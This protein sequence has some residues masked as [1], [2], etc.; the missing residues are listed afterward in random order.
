MKGTKSS[1]KD[2]ISPICYLLPF[3]LAC[4]QNI[5]VQWLFLLFVLSNSVTYSYY[6]WSSLDMGV[7]STSS[8]CL[9]YAD[10]D[11]TLTPKLGMHF[12][13]LPKAYEF[14]NV[15]AK[16]AWFSVRKDLRRS[17][18]GEIVWKPFFFQRSVRQTRSIGLIRNLFKGVI[19]KHE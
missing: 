8:P 12:E 4:K 13:D 11:E 19:V 5:C 9:H 10:V 7:S 2:Y 6:L 18:D 15:H 17:K 3:R 14:Y 1:E 16:A